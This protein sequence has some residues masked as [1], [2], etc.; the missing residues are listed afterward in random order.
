METCVV[1]VIFLVEVSYS[2]RSSFRLAGR[3]RLTDYYRNMLKT[4]GSASPAPVKS[5][6]LDVQNIGERFIPNGGTAEIYGCGET[7]DALGQYNVFSRE[8]SLFFSIF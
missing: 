3:G 5:Q 2:S 1:W 8:T 4:R 7:G 6:Q